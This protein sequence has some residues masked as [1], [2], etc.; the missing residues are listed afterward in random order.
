MLQ[1]PRIDNI[2]QPITKTNPNSSYPKNDPSHPQEHRMHRFL[3][4]DV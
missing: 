1:I 3:Q 2:K 4:V